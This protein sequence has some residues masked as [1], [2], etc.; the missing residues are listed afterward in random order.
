MRLTPGRGTYAVVFKCTNSQTGQAY[1]MKM[2]EKKSLSNQRK[3]KNV[4]EE[5]QNLKKLNHHSVVKYVSDFET[6]SRKCIVMEYAGKTSLYDFLK[7][8][9]A[10]CL[11]VVDVLLG[12]RG[13]RHLQE[14][15]RCCQ[16]LS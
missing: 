14:T 4:Q 1:A 2:Y 5:I 6:T 13:Q 8:R 15:C 7:K 11:S 10:G 16:A 9:T 3:L 12:N